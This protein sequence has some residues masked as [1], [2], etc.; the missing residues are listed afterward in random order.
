MYLMFSNKHH[1]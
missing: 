1:L